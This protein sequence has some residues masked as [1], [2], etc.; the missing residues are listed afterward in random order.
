MIQIRCSSLLI[1]ILIDIYF[2][3]HFCDAQP[4]WACSVFHP[5]KFSLNFRIILWAI[6]CKLVII[7]EYPVGR[8]ELKDFDFFWFCTHRTW[9]H[10]TLTLWKSS[11]RARFFYCLLF[12]V[13]TFI[14]IFALE[15]KADFLLIV[16]LVCWGLHWLQFH[17]IR[18]FIQSSCF[19]CESVQYELLQLT[20][21][22]L[23][24]LRLVL[25]SLFLRVNWFYKLTWL[26]TGGLHG[27]RNW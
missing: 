13:P 21:L 26:A 1:L 14:L 12:L 7:H 22:L 15:T 19:P 6:K 17:E 11:F 10:T 24:H 20:L 16:A 9:D 4:E 2:K 5:I 27:W 8:T 3:F 25:W 23:E 18:I